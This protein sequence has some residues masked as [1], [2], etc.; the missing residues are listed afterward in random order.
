MHMFSCSDGKVVSN[1]LLKLSPVDFESKLML[2]TLDR[3]SV[4]FIKLKS[5]TLKK[6][7]TSCY[8][9]F[10]VWYGDS[11]SV[12]SV[13][14]GC[15]V[16]ILGPFRGLHRYNQDGVTQ[17]KWKI[18]FYKLF[19]KQTW[20]ES[21]AEIQKSSLWV[22]KKKKRMEAKRVCAKREEEKQRH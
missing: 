14:G 10:P 15:F 7:P 17:N 6:K 5:S 19:A 16:L 21:P 22:K 1:I 3:T 12:L 18:I 4:Q 13:C 8:F 9:T 2:R 11:L 20:L